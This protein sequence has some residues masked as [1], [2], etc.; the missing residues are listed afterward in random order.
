[1]AK[2]NWQK[3]KLLKLMDMLRDEATPEHPLTTEMIR[4]RLRAMG[5]NSDKG[6][7]TRDI[8]ALK[9]FD[10]EIGV[11]QIG[12]EKGYFIE[13]ANAETF[14]T[15]EV[16]I[17]IDAIEAAN[18]IPV[19]QTNE[20]REKVAALAGDRRQELLSTGAVCFN[21]RKHDNEA[22]YLNVSTIKKAI[23]AR[24][25]ISFV[26]FDK[27]ENNQRI[28][29]K[30]RKRYVTDPMAVI[31]NEDNYYCMCFS[32]K[33]DGYTN[34]RVDRMDEVLVE[35]EEVSESAILPDDDIAA[36]T[37]QVFKM[38]G[39]PATEIT[40]EFDRKLIGVIQ[41][42][43]GEDTK[44]IRTGKDKCVASITVQVSPTFWGWLF[45]F[46]GEMTIVSPEQLRDDYKK[47]IFDA[48]N[49]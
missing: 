1:M 11:K 31:W 19:D 30:D 10:Y 38:Y 32:S 17:I 29:R 34:Y 8:G 14:K 15:A 16:E 2:E 13:K 12:H 46:V 26:Y 23:A 45:Q 28:Y 47:R 22:V 41:D 37:D 3:I 25:K 7:L 24:R 42:K 43:F 21:K 4:D 9:S 27:D 49:M 35:K 5:I 44:I 39:G 40:I 33:Y 6:T 20:L 48:V 36:Y 18:F